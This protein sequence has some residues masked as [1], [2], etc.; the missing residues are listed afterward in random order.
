MILVNSL[1]DNQIEVR[2]R[3]AEAL[4]T[5]LQG[6]F[7]ETTAELV[8]KFS[9]AAHSKDLIQAHG[10]VLGLSAIVLAFPYS[11][12]EFLPGVLMTICRFATD[13]NATIRVSIRSVT[14]CELHRLQEAVK[15]AL[16][17]FKRT[18]QDSWREHEQQFNEDQLMV[19]R[20]LL[21]SPNYYV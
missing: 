18:H 17:E 8:M 12:P 9:Q 21:I 6:K 20:D 2:E 5:L 10:G 14:S 4:S 1:N 16:S 7:F 11:V 15:R 3:A 19:L 13:K